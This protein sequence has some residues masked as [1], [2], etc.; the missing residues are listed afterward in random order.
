MRRIAGHRLLSLIL[1]LFLSLLGVHADV[2]VDS[3]LAFENTASYSMSIRRVP[4]GQTGEAFCERKL[5]EQAEGLLLDRR[6]N[7][8]TGIRAGRWFTLFLLIELLLYETVGE[9]VSFIRFVSGSNRCDRRIL[10]YIH[11]KDGKKA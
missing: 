6:E 8:G 3:P 1:I 4:G 2:S 11:H 7:H 9:N 5:L 10:E